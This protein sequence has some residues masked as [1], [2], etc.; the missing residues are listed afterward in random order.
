MPFQ[1][2]LVPLPPGVTAADLTDEQLRA[3][4][5]AFSGVSFMLIAMCPTVPKGDGFGP[6]AA[7]A[8]ATG[9]DFFTVLHGDPQ[10]LVAGKDA[11]AGVIDR[12]Y[13]KKGIM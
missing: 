9:C 11:L 6:A 7:W 5:L 2:M 10:V 12:L 13:K 1:G 3:A 4:A 8:D